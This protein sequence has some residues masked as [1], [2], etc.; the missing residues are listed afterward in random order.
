MKIC[1]KNGLP[2]SIHGSFAPGVIHKESLGCLWFLQKFFAAFRSAPPECP[3]HEDNKIQTM[4]TDFNFFRE[5]YLYNS[6]K[7]DMKEL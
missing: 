5:F 4:F 6:V 3:L 1:N 2:Y 7:R